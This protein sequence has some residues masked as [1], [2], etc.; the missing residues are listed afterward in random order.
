MPSRQDQLHSYQFMIQRVVSA[1]VMRETDPLRSPFRRLAGAT[2]IGGLLAALGFGGAAAF[3][4]ISPGTST[5]WRDES[6]VIVEKETG[7]LYVYR[8][9]RLQP[10]LNFTSALL[11]LNAPDP[12]VV[13]V[14]RSAL[15][16]V[17]RSAPV[18]IVGAPASL[19]PVEALSHGSWTVCSSSVPSVSVVL[20]GVA[21]GR[22]AGDSGLLA[23]GVD[24]ATYLLFHGQKHLIRDAATV[25]I[26]LSW[27]TKPRAHLAP[28]FLNTVPSGADVR[29]PALPPSAR[30]YQVENSYFM[31]VP[32][33]FA[34]LTPFQYR[35]LHAGA[36]S[37]LSLADFTRLGGEKPLPF[38]WDASLPA[39]VP[40]ILDATAQS[41]CSRS[42]TLTVGAPVPASRVVVRP[43]TA[44]VVA[45]VSAPGAAPGGFA[46][47]TDLGLRYAVPSAEVLTALGYGSVTPVPVP[48]DLLALVP[49]GPALDP[50]AARS[51]PNCR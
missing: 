7:A 27:N 5:A 32:G 29:R 45:A 51:C 11:I 44:A 39:D 49:Q 23:T 1:L 16:G 41:V 3:A 38:G 4:V 14:S 20:G 48:S 15:V 46:L 34:A 35:L 30:F 37:S 25:L 26:Q 36:V 19:P 33:G 2:L 10:V 18:G 24:G 40:A 8:V 6:A 22:P 13:S 50:V 47:V 17:P 28:E 42:S 21:G 12:K 43:G 9:E 31:G